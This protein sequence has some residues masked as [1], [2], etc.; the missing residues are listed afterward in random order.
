MLKPPI[1]FFLQNVQ[2]LFCTGYIFCTGY[3]WIYLNNSIFMEN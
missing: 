3:K 1:L 2:K